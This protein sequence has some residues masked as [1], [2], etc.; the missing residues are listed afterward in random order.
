MHL[1]DFL[2]LDS[3]FI[4]TAS[5]QKSAREIVLRFFLVRNDRETRRIPRDGTI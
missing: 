1:E 4:R 2:V 5:A 3:G